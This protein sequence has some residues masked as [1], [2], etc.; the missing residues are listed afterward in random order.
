MKKINFQNGTLISRGKVEVDG[1]V[2][3]VEPPQYEGTTPLS[4]E[5]LNE[6]QKNIEEEFSTLKEIMEGSVLYENKNGNTG[7]ITLRQSVETFDYIEIFYKNVDNF[8]SSVKVEA[9]NKKN[10]NLFTTFINQDGL[11]VNVSSAIKYISEEFISNIYYG[12]ASGSNVTP[13]NDIKITKV[14]GY[15]Y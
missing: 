7:N 12:G 8:F 1:K 9:P 3:D 14:V 11:V 4:A 13:N 6:L 5:I 15:K 2:Y 10:V